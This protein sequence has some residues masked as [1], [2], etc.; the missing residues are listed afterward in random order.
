VSRFHSR[1][2]KALRLEPERRR[3]LFVAGAAVTLIAVMLKRI[4]YSRTISRLSRRLPPP[5]ETADEA[6]S[7]S[8]TIERDAWAVRAAGENLPW[9][10]CLPRSVALWW[11]LAR[12][13]IVTEIQFGVRHG[14]DDFSAHAWVEW[15]QRT[16]SD[17]VDPR[18]LYSHLGA[19]S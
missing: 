3:R 7:T 17:L 4:G 18:E 13:S 6:A 5:E 15:R 19:S 14:D 12:Q 8:R 16:I 10:S 11:L 1:I 9:G 2:L